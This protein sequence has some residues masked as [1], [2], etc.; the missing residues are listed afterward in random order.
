MSLWYFDNGPGITHLVLSLCLSQEIQFYIQFYY[1]VASLVHRLANFLENLS[2]ILPNKFQYGSREALFLFSYGRVVTIKV[3][4][5]LKWSQEVSCQFF[6]KSHVDSSR[7]NLRSYRREDVTF[8]VFQFS[9]FIC[10][11]S[12][13]NCISHIQQILKSAHQVLEFTHH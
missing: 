8:I 10:S 3:L 1:M 6:K 13:W 11:G 2:R 12:M 5:V 4:H 9:G 7:V